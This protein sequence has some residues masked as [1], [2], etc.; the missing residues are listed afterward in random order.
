MEDKKYDVDAVK[1]RLSEYRDREREID[2][3]IER[4]DRHISRMK[5]VGA[6]TVSDMP[7]GTRTS[8]DRIADML[9]MK[10]EI[11]LEI[12][13]LVQIQKEERAAIGGILKKLKKP[14]ER[15]V[16]QMRYFDA[17]DWYGVVDMLFGGKED[18]LDR[19]ETYLRRTHKIHG[20]ALL[21]MAKYIEESKADTDNTADC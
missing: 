15:A 11:E 7:K 14:D 2:N 13:S 20:S 5:S 8:N 3:Q 17:S 6:Q 21:N 9:A 18:F 12:S 1:N 19:E 10:E 4:L 16:I